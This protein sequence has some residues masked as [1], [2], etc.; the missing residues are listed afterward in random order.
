M[1]NR[2][3]ARTVA[4]QTLYEWD[5]NQL[6]GDMVGEV[7]TRNTKEFAEGFDEGDFAR[8]LVQAVVQKQ[9]TLD[10][11]IA[12]YAPEWPIE[13]ITLIDR[14]ILRLGIVELLYLDN[15]PD[16]VAINEAIELGKTFGGVSS[17]KFI[18]GVLGAIYRDK[19]KEEE[20]EE[21]NGNKK[22]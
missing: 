15:I 20:H 11:L 4:L 17:G 9:G 13:K 7:L 16:K 3:L 5:F 14:N 22:T 6:T 10:G 19:L 2:H 1:S 12:K 21:G 8:E 18:N